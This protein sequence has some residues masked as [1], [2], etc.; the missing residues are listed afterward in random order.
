[1][2]DDLDDEEDVHADNKR[3]D[4]NQNKTVASKDSSTHTPAAGPMKENSNKQKESIETN[5]DENPYRNATASDNPSSSSTNLSSSTGYVHSGSRDQV[6]DR[7]DKNQLST[8]LTQ[9]INTSSTISDQTSKTDEKGKPIQ[10][11]VGKLSWETTEDGLKLYFEK[12]GEVEAVNLVKDKYTG[13]LRG[14][15]FVQFKDIAALEKCCAQPSHFVDGKYI[16]VKL[17]KAS[18]TRGITL[19][20][21]TQGSSAPTQTQHQTQPFRSTAPHSR[22]ENPQNESRKIFVGGL[23]PDVKESDLI[24]FARKYGEVES[25]AVMVDQNTKRSRGFGF[26]TFVNPKD[27]EQAS[28]TGKGDLGGR[29]IEVQMYTAGGGGGQPGFGRGG[30]RGRGRGGGME[31]GGGASRGFSR[32]GFRNAPISS[33]Q[34]P[35][36]YQQSQ[37]YRGDDTRGQGA[38]DF[39]DRQRPPKRDRS[40]ERRD[41][42]GRGSRS[43]YDR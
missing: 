42:H 34:D 29:E 38:G 25:A 3:S 10:V 16:E 43:R 37:G 40:H 4:V 22:A 18:D 1:M 2:Y 30:F 20:T 41:D 17:S 31:R 23:G 36:Q 27:A 8:T 11:F 33:N 21:T 12:Y 5:Q 6:D 7:G 39:Q 24:E 28:S 35:Q 32:G 14:F 26:I 19:P 9:P 13:Q 15:G